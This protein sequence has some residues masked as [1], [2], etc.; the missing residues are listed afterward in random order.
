MVANFN[1]CR[2]SG[3]SVLFCRN[4]AHI[5]R[6]KFCRLAFRYV[7]R[8]NIA[9][10]NARYIVRRRWW[11]NC[12]SR[13]YTKSIYNLAQKMQVACAVNCRSSFRSLALNKRQSYSSAFYN[14]Y[15]LR[16][17]LCKIFYKRLLVAVGN[18]SARFIRFF[19]G[20][21]NLFY[22]VI[23]LQLSGGLKIRFRLLLLHQ[24]KA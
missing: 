21:F 17:R 6:H 4:I 12:F 7:G 8:T 9:C 19:F 13:L 14:G 10:G 23:K 3:I 18:H 1:R 11:R 15:R 2:N 5:M 22:A 16:F 24:V 20:A